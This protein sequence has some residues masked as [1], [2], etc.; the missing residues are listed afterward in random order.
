MMPYYEDQLKIIEH[1]RELEAKHGKKYMSQV[2]LL[3]TS[4]N[5]LGRWIRSS[6]DRRCQE[7]LKQVYVAFRSSFVDPN[8]L[9]VQCK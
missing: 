9:K 8:H 5:F 6:I 2:L 3:E 1:V 7:I 4:L